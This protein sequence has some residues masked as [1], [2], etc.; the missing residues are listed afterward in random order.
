V[1][2]AERQPDSRVTLFGALNALA[3]ILCF[4]RP[5]AEGFALTQRAINLHATY[6]QVQLAVLKSTAAYCDPDR[7]HVAE[8]EAALNGAL[9]EVQG[10]LGS[11]HW[12]E[13]IARRLKRFHQVWRK[14]RG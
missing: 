9:Q 3:D 10:A 11:A 6:W 5:D 2:I 7:S 4:R 12:H 1:A 8:N 13:D 14:Q